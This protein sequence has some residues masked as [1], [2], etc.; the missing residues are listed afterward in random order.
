MAKVSVTKFFPSA[1]AKWDDGQHRLWSEENITNIFKAICDVDLTQT[2][3]ISNDGHWLLV[4]GYLFYNDS[5]WQSGSYFVD[6]DA[7]TN[8]IKFD[9]TVEGGA[10]LYDSAS[11]LN[12][13]K[14][15]TAQKIKFKQDSIDDID[16][17]K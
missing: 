14:G 10:I 2:P 8:E 15:G 5:E 13:P 11:N 12:N 6:I 16:L 1:K 7:T 9:D 3:V 4:A 17:N